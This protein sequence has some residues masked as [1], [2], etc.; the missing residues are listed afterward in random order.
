[1]EYPTHTR[2]FEDEHGHERTM[3]LRR[4]EDQYYLLTTTKRCKRDGMWTELLQGIK[5]DPKS[6]D[7][8]RTAINSYPK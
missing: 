4:T 5:L 2:F 1:M 6:F 8:A 3:T 7:V